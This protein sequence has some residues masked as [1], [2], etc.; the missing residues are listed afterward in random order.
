MAVKTSTIIAVNGRIVTANSIRFT[1]S[2]TAPKN[3]ATA[4]STNSKLE[5][6]LVV[7]VWESKQQNPG[8]NKIV[9]LGPL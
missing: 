6:I 8:Y 9:V 7:A 2:E 1:W 5:L 3:A 4:V